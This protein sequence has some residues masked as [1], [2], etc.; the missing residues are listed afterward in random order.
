MTQRSWQKK[1]GSLNVVTAA[2]P[3]YLEQHGTP[4]TV[5]D[6]AE[7]SAVHYFSSRAGRTLDLNF[8]GAGA[9]S[10]IKMKGNLAFNDMEAYV[11]AGAGG[12]GIIQAPCHIVHAYLEKG[13]LVE[14]LQDIRPPAKDISAVFPQNRHP[15]RKLHMFIDWAASLFGRSP[16]LSRLNELTPSARDVTTK[17]DASLEYQIASF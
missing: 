12:A 14:I 13:A 6:L 11:L 16:M 8:A 9:V 3:D 5:A 2:S 17:M 15:S 4:R 10:E 7:H 1:L